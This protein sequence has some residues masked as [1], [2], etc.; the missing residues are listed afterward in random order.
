MAQY[1]C[2]KCECVQFDF[3][4]YFNTLQEMLITFNGL[5]VID[6]FVF[7]FQTLTVRMTYNSEYGVGLLSC[8]VHPIVMTKMC[9]VKEWTILS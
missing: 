1:F 7:T 6:Y 8:V 2:S 5:H 4:N 9:D 3:M